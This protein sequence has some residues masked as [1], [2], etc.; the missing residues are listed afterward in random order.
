M[1]QKLILEY[2]EQYPNEENP[3]TYLP[4]LG[5]DFLIEVLKNRNSRKINFDFIDG[6]DDDFNLIYL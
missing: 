4:Q 2:I 1:L 3:F 5:E 6:V